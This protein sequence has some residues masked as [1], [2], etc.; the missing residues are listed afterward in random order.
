MAHPLSQ[1]LPSLIAGEAERAAGLFAAEPEIDLPLP[2]AVKGLDGL[3]WLARG[4][5]SWLGTA[6]VRLQPGETWAGDDRAAH[7]AVVWLRRGGRE[8]EMPIL[9][10]A[11]IDGNK[12]AA[13]RGYHSTWPLAGGHVLRE[14]LLPVADVDLTEPAASYAQAVA[15]GDL[16]ALD[17]VFA[18]AG[19]VREPAGGAFCHSDDTRRAFYAGMLAG[20]G[21]P[22]Q[23]CTY[24]DTGRVAFWEYLLDEWGGRPLH[25]Q[26]GAACLERDDGGR[27]VSVRVY[28]D[29]EP[30]QQRFGPPSLV[31]TIRFRLA[32]GVAPGEYLRAD[33]R[34]EREHLGRRP[35]FLGRTVSRSREGEWL[36]ICHWESLE[37]ARSAMAELAAEEA[38]LELAQLRAHGTGSISR[39]T[40]VRPLRPSLAGLGGEREDRH[41]LLGAQTG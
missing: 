27:L 8:T 34:V 14:R 6:D 9:L 11:D 41:P 2:A 10:V 3:R 23:L 18:P 32:A 25:G 19:H 5:R 17:A 13:V 12:L 4:T 28:D 16:E 24:T 33:A 1:L 21:W 31:E 7:E 38:V 22:L 30:P 35:G 20:G 37:D 36:V 29:V 15:R 39:Y 26:P 40:R